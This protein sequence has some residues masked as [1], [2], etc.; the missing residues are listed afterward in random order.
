[1]KAK[2][3]ITI[4]VCSPHGKI[5]RSILSR[6]NVMNIPSLFVAIRK[7]SWGGLFPADIAD[8]ENDIRKS[9]LTYMHLKDNRIEDGHR[10]TRPPT[11]KGS[12]K[13]GVKA[14]PEENINASH[15]NEEAVSSRRSNPVLKSLENMK[16]KRKEVSAPAAVAPAKPLTGIMKTLANVRRKRTGDS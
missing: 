6:G 14:I 2:G 11:A 9:A 7:T 15:E 1:M 13:E 10:F 8:S 5:V 3:H 4:D 16:Q 12:S